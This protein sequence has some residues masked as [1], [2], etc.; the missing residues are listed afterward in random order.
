LYE[1]LTQSLDACAA[2]QG[3]SALFCG[4]PVLQVD[5]TLA[6]LPGVVAVTDLRS[7]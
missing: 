6:P 4:N 7:A 2:T 1:V 5:A 3:E